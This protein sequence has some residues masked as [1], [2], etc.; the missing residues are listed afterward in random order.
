[1]TKR[2]LASTSTEMSYGATAPQ[3]GRT[4]GRQSDHDSTPAVRDGLHNDKADLFC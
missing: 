2:L 3:M 1:M 4:I